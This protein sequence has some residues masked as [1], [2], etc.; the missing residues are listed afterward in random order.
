M[1][2]SRRI[3]TRGSLRTFL[4]IAVVVF[5]AGAIIGYLYFK[6]RL[7]IKF[8]IIEEIEARK[9]EEKLSAKKEKPFPVGRHRE[10][11]DDTGIISAR[12]AVRNYMKPY[13]TRLQDL[14]AKG[15]IVYVDLGGELRRN[16][17]GDALEELSMIAGLYKSLKDNIPEMTAMKILIEGKEVESLGGHID[18]SGPIEA[19]VLS[20]EY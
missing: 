8:P 6:P 14:Y 18:I 19:S 13:N 3:R 15:E 7:A 1:R 16:F 5:M 4:L 20:M 2:R 11:P 10:S 12:D 9:L 17:K